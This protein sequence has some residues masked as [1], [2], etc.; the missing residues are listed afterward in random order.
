MK[1]ALTDQP[2]KAPS[3]K[4]WAVIISGALSSVGTIVLSIY[5]PLFATPEIV[6]LIQAFAAA[7]TATIMSGVGYWVRERA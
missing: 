7:L 5:A 4:M 1:A 2:S 3:R 6:N